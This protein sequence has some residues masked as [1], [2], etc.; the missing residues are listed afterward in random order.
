MVLCS[1]SAKFSSKFLFTSVVKCPLLLPLVGLPFVQS[2][3]FEWVPFRWLPF[4]SIGFVMLVL[5]VAVLL[6]L[7]LMDGLLFKAS[8]IFAE[9]KSA[10]KSVSGVNKLLFSILELFGG[11]RWKPFLLMAFFC[12]SPSFKAN[13]FVGV[14]CLLVPFERIP[15]VVIGADGLLKRL[16]LSFDESKSIFHRLLDVVFCWWLVLPFMMVA[17][18]AHKLLLFSSIDL[19]VPF[20][21]SVALFNCVGCCFCEGANWAVFVIDFNGLA[22]SK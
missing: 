15:F 13:P 2:N 16:L 1:K 14:P 17:F 18:D 3:P 7:L 20:V 6:L 11:G 22:G 19:A 21:N 9:P 8:N 5:L 10:T 4:K 12:L